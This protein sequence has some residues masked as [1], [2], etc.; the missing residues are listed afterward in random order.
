VSLGNTTEVGC[1][2]VAEDRVQELGHTNIP[3]SV[4]FENAIHMRVCVP[5]KVCV[6]TPMLR[7]RT[8]TMSC[9]DAGGPEDQFHSDNGFGSRVRSLPPRSD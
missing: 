5:E 9:H 3:N 4:C 7:R 8:H 6:S 2:W 1:H